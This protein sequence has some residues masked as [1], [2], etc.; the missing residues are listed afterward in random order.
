MLISYLKETYAIIVNNDTDAVTIVQN[1]SDWIKWF[2]LVTLFSALALYS[3]KNSPLRERLG[4]YTF[5]SIMA[6]GWIIQIAAHLPYVA[7]ILIVAEIIV[8]VLAISAIIVWHNATKYE[9][10]ETDHKA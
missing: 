1:T 2:G 6:L 7:T 4:M 10:Q 5:L 3:A 9:T 8:I